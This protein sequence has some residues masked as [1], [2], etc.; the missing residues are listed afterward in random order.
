LPANASIEQR[1]LNIDGFA[2]TTMPRFSA[3]AGAMDHLRY[4]L[5]NLA[6]YARHDGRSAVIGVGSGRDLLSAHIFGFRDSIGIELN[7]VFVELLTNPVLLR[8]YAGVANLP[9]IRFV[10]DDGRNW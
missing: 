7:P 2:G 4:D 5:T 6:Y 10:V 8:G 1:E 3:E 9:G